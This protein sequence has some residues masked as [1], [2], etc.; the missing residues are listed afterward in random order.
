MSERDDVNSPPSETMLT[1]LTRR[2]TMLTHADGRNCT[3]AVDAPS[4]DETMLT[5]TAQPALV[6]RC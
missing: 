2:E 6:R 4:T 5:H 3:L 1:R